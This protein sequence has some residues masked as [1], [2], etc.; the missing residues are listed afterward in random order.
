MKKVG[1]SDPANLLLRWNGGEDCVRYIYEIQYRCCC[2]RLNLFFNKI[3]QEYLIVMC[4]IYNVLHKHQSMLGNMEFSATGWLNFYW[5]WIM[6][7]Y[8]FISFVSFSFFTS[9]FSHCYSSFSS[10]FVDDIN[11]LVRWQQGQIFRKPEQLQGRKHFRLSSPRRSGRQTT[12]QRRHRF[13][14]K[15]ESSEGHTQW[16][17]F[18]SLIQLAQ[19]HA[20]LVPPQSTFVILVTAQGLAVGYHNHTWSIRKSLHWL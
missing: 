4:F 6:W 11:S 1:K 12:C 2:C 13:P 5:N 14:R 17:S 16:A 9:F 3:M 7:T 8:Y 19:N 18:V 15:W 10:S 20:T